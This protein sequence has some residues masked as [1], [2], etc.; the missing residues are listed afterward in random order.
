MNTNDVYAIL[1][2]ACYKFNFLL[3]SY[4]YFLVLNYKK[5]TKQKFFIIKVVYSFTSYSLDT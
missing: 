3:K 5:I 4:I 2:L 1:I